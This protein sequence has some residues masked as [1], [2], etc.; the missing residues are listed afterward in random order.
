MTDGYTERDFERMDRNQNALYTKLSDVTDRLEAVE[1]ENERLRDRVAELEKIVDPSGDAGEYHEL[2][3]PQKV[4]QLRRA[5]MLKAARDGGAAAMSYRD[6]LAVFNYQPSDGH[7]YNLMRY[8]AEADGFTYN[9]ATGEKR[10]TVKTDAV[11]DETLIHSVNNA[12]DAT[13]A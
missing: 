8:A 13:P 2:T 5:L 10:L 1:E 3:R 7:A 4:F 12:T 11:S 9:D 6:V